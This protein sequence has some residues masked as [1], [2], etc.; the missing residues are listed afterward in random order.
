M[1]SAAL[2]AAL[3]GDGTAVVAAS[4]RLY[5]TLFTVALGF[6]CAT[7]LWG[8]VLAPFNSYRPSGTDTVVFGA[9]LAAGWAAALVRRHHLFYVVRRRPE[10]LLIPVALG[11]AALWADGGW[12]STL[13]LASYGA[14]PVA[15]VAVHLRWAM[16]CALLLALGYVG[17]LAINGYSWSELEHLKDAD[18]VVANTGGYLIAGYFFAAPVAWLG[19]YVAR[20]NQVVDQASRRPSAGRETERLRTK[21]LSPR[22]VHVTQLVAAGLSNDE[23][24][25]K[26]KISSR[27]VQS[28]VS[29][30]LRKTETRNRTELGLLAKTEG[31]I[32]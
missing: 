32:R 31:L 22:E 24:A 14:L 18:S 11:V 27:T 28:H 29:A 13:Y 1:E 3:T 4:E 16:G 15:A 6:G 10:L 20:I 7:A 17:G 26:L 12:R 21:T 30:A 8:V 25:G 19:G 9:V 5:Q 2:P 23:I